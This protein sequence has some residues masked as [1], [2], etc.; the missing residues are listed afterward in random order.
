MFL[1]ET[2]MLLLSLEAP[3][4]FRDFTPTLEEVVILL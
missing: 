4:N 2:R 1:I 3:L